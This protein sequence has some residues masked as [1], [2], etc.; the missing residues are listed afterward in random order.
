ML[1]TAYLFN[2]FPIPYSSEKTATIFFANI[3]EILKIRKN[4]DK[5][6]IL[7]SKEKKRPKNSPDHDLI[8]IYLTA[9]QNLLNLFDA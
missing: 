8:E 3:F 2:F 9:F 6:A 5:A 1:Q 7:M 4:I